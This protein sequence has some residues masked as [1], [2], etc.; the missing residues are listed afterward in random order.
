MTAASHAQSG[1]AALTDH[2]LAPLWTASRGWWILFACSSLGTLLLIAMVTYTVIAGIGLWGNNIP[3]AW[4]FAITNFVWWIGI[5]HA[6]TFI[7]AFLLLLNQHWRGSVNRVAEAMTIFA[8]VN[9]AI[10][11]VLHLGRPWFA[12]W[13]IPYPATMNVWPNFKS[14]LPWDVAAVTTYFTVSVLFWYLGLVPDLATARDRARTRVRR[15]IYGIFAMGWRG[16]GFQWRRYQVAYVLLAALATP[17]VISVHS[18]V[19]LDFSIAQLPGWHSTIF[20]PYFVVG[21]IY[22]GLA[23]VLILVLPMR[24]IFSLYDVITEKHLDAIAKLMLVMGLMLAYS[25]VIET[26]I[27]WYGGNPEERYTYLFARPFGPYA[28]VYWVMTLFNVV[29][30]Q[31]FWSRRLRT[32][33]VVLFLASIAILSGMWMERFVIIVTSLNRDFLTSSWHMYFPTWVDWSILSGTLGLFGFLFLLFVKFVPSVAIS[34]VK[35]LPL[36]VGSRQT[37]GDVH[38]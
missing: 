15:I 20:P 19:S 34:E 36:E 18:V 9:A 33:T 26:F 17:L 2:L 35:A 23:M 4:A 38:G 10:F 12:Y 1:E 11:P 7:S 16:S 6:G 5:G 32:N 29:S 27:A 30:P 25:Y 3:V 13:L 14:A 37:L 22:S 24:R 8:L 28:V 31:L 21:A